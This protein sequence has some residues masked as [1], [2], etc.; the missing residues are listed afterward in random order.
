MPVEVFL[1]GG[2][3]LARSERAAWDAWAEERLALGGDGH[4]RPSA[5]PI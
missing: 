3:I 4:F 2:A 5:R 1:R